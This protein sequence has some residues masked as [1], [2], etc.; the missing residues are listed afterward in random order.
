MIPAYF[1]RRLRRLRR[2]R[3]PKG[4]AT[5]V[6][7]ALGALCNAWLQPS[8]PAA[9]ETDADET[10]WQAVPRDLPEV[11][12][13]G[14]LRHLGVPYANFVTGDGGGLDM[15]LIQE[16]AEELGVEHVYVPASWEDIFPRLLG[17]EVARNGGEVTLGAPVA[18]EGDLIANGLTVL[19]WREQII[20]YSHPTF[21]TQIWLLTRDDAE[22]EPV[23]P[24]GSI[25]ADLRAVNACLN[26]RTLLCKGGTCLD[27][28]LYGLRQLGA[29][30][31]E[32]EGSLNELAP[33]VIAN[34]AE[35]TIL[36]VPDALV[37]LRKWPT[38]IKVI[39]PI[40][41]EQTM[42]V[43]F[44][45]SAPQLRAAFNAFFE[46]CWE[47]GRYR[48]W[49]VEYYPTALKYYPDFFARRS[50]AELPARVAPVVPEA[51]ETLGAPK[52][53]VAERE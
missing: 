8:V 4:V 9:S 14:V 25:E 40:S 48:E 53:P 21:P 49:I 22:L 46:E 41:P 33:A 19:P 36:D 43:G 47:S 39:G 3:A 16:F 18:I 34:R 12:S 15:R 13:S 32:F 5:V 23:R 20:D 11:R 31:I 2:L 1:L 28:E 30:T 51:L 52:A 35:M 37:A 10:A 45:E 27:P 24:S 38:R 29:R 17:R 26:G 6:L 7:C 44:P 50:P 42:G